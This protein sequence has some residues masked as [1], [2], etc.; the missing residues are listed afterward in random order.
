MKYNCSEKRKKKR[1]NEETFCTKTLQMR[2]QREELRETL[3]LGEL[4]SREKRGT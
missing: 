1:K 2:K 4:C 3:R